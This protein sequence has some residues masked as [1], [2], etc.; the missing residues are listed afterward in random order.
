MKVLVYVTTSNIY[1]VTLVIPKSQVVMLA[2]KVGTLVD[3]GGNSYLMNAFMLP[4][5]TYLYHVIPKPTVN[6]GTNAPYLLWSSLALYYAKEE[7]PSQKIPPHLCH[8][9]SRKKEVTPMILPIEMI[10]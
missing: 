8:Q 2:K 5:C 3:Q 4:S 1:T 7:I 9:G 6:G 10:M